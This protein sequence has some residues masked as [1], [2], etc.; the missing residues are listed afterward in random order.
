M[1]D[2]SDHA[3]RNVAS[4]SADNAR[5]PGS[6]TLVRLLMFAPLVAVTIAAGACDREP[7]SDGGNCTY[8]GKTLAKGVSIPA[9]DGC[10]TCSCGADGQ[11]ACTL[12]GCVDA[13]SDGTPRDV[14]GDFT[15]TAE[16]CGGFCTY[17]GIV[18]PAGATIPALDGCNT[19][20]CTANGVACTE[21]ACIDAGQP[22]SCTYA[23]KAYPVGATFSATDGCN[24]CSCSTAGVA[25]TKVA[26]LDG[27]GA[28][29]GTTGVCTP[30]QDQTCNEN[31]A[32]SSL[33]GKCQPDGTC[34]CASGAPNP[35]TGRCADVTTGC[36]IRPGE[37]LPFGTSFLCAD[38]CNTCTCVEPIPIVTMTDLPCGGPNACN[39]D[40]ALY[41][42]GF[43]GG[44]V[45]YRDHARL[46]PNSINGGDY[47]IWRTYTSRDAETGTVLE[48]CSVGLPRCGDPAAIDI[49]DII[50]DL[51]DPTVQK[52][53]LSTD[54]SPLLFGLDTRPA[55]SPVFS[56]KRGAREILIGAPCDGASGCAD[57]PPA[58][59]KLENDLLALNQ[60]QL[61]SPRCAAITTGAFDCG[62]TK[63]QTG[64]EYC[65]RAT[66]NA[67][68]PAQK[69]ATCRPYPSSSCT[70]CDCAAQ[71]A[72]AVLGSVGSLSCAMASNYECFDGLGGKL[73]N[74]SSSGTLTIICV[75]R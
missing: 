2:V 4:R 11:V 35:S 59:A 18:Y 68:Q 56:I 45:A 19:C 7:L 46:T 73:M 22:G 23:G 43:I 61:A 14:V 49:G 29:R 15:C 30:G 28:D 20:A 50:A 74:G 48:P 64:F 21:K 62:S 72:F 55:D 5:R 9:G 16:G 57:I 37:L 10:N 31:P 54:P 70:T 66:A 17:E 1:N 32:L 39:L 36:E 60:Q 67:A 51:S 65:A 58:V 75:A 33:R 41:D 40:E 27:G 38:G 25:C 34:V 26:C 69:I 53:L 6:L 71:D 8:Q 47:G 42:Y 44:L 13:G 24:T 63:C 3:P 52:A 12:I